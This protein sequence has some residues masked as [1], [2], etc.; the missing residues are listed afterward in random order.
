MRQDKVKQHREKIAKFL[1]IINNNSTALFFLSKVNMDNVGIP[2]K[3]LTRFNGKNMF[4]IIPNSLTVYDLSFDMK[5][6]DKVKDTKNR[7][8]NKKHQ[9]IKL[10]IEDGANKVSIFDENYC[11]GKLSIFNNIVEGTEFGK[12]FQFSDDLLIRFKDLNGLETA[13]KLYMSFMATYINLKTNLIY[14]SFELFGGLY[15]VFFS[16]FGALVWSL[17][18][19]YWFFGFWLILIFS[20]N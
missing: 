9:F 18:R 5:L 19:F 14:V 4:F 11:T 1:K 17:R 10:R 16:F 6:P 20:F 3:I 12:L 7:I 2:S 8:P 15:W 13:L